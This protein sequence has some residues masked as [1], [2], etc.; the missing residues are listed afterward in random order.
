[1]TKH[2]FARIRSFL[3]SETVLAISALAALASMA[4]LPLT[5]KTAGVYAGYIDIRTIGLL[6]CLMTVVAGFGRAGLL[7]RVRDWLMGRVGSARSLAFVLVNVVFAS[8]MLVT[9]DVAL[10]TFVPLAL[11]L[12]LDASPRTTIATVVA[13]TVAANLG[14]MCTPI[15]NPQNI[16][17]V[18]AFGMDLGTFFATM[19]PFGAVSYLACTALVLFVPAED[20][21]AE[22]GLGPSA[23][24][25]KLLGLYLLLFLACLACVGRLIGWE[26][27]CVAVIA[28]CLALDRRVFAAVAY[29]LLATFACF[30]VFV[31]NLKHVEPVVTLVGGMLQGREVMVSAIASQ[32]ISNVPAAIMLSGFTDN[33]RALLVGTNI[34]GLGTPVA[35]LAS[36]ISLRIYAKMPHARTG[37]YLAWFTAANIALLV[38]LLAL[39]PFLMG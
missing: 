30:F 4:A 11:A 37:R 22:R 16:Y 31:G 27:C 2:R 17:L 3:A 24:D 39:A 28:G 25:R 13:L 38:P 36:L 29:S 18:S 26:V 8:S 9:N 35:S 5:P 10:I 6:F 15:G 34:G 19:L 1:M 20:I 33:A 21:A 32:V 7:E 23:I 14:S 12:F